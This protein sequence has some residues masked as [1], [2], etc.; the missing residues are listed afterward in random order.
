MGSRIPHIT[1]NIPYLLYASCFVIHCWFVQ[2]FVKLD[3]RMSG[4]FVHKMQQITSANSCWYR[5][6]GCLNPGTWWPFMRICNFMLV[7]MGSINPDPPVPYIFRT[8]C[9]QAFANIAA[10]YRSPLVPNIIGKL[11]ESLCQW[12][13]LF[14]IQRCQ[15]FWNLRMI[16]ILPQD[17]SN[18]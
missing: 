7:F 8:Y 1:F 9:S 11:I 15:S 4:V 12:T 18:L 16:M 13:R 2:F 5:I 10:N 3:E 14:F 6:P 17:F